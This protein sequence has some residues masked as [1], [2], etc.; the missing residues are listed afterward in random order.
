[1]GRTLGSKNKKQKRWSK[2]LLVGKTMPPLYH[3]LPGR[4]FEHEKSQVLKWLARD[5]VIQDWVMEQLKSAGYII[6]N[7]ETGQWK[8]VDYE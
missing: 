2:K 7:P 8:G 6:Y 3:T 4:D 1:M 5:L